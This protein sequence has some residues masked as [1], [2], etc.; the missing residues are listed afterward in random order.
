M[1]G[2]VCYHGQTIAVDEAA[3]AAVELDVVQI[4][5]GGCDLQQRRL[6]QT[7]KKEKKAGK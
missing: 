1:Q 7:E 2:K 5:F 3:D 6:R 4:E